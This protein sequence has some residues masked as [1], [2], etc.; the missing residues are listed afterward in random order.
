MKF[1]SNLTIIVTMVSVFAIIGSTSFLGKDKV[2]AQSNIFG[3]NSGGLI[4]NLFKNFGT[5]GAPSSTP[6]VPPST[7]NNPFSSMFGSAP[8]STP[9]NTPVEKSSPTSNDKV[10]YHVGEHYKGFTFD[11]KKA[12]ENK[13]KEACN[14]N[15]ECI[16]CIDHRA[17][18]SNELTGYEAV[19]CLKDPIHSY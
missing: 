7:S 14:G 11:H 13:A 6:S 9:S 15:N 19:K 1:K 3:D 10:K 5:F 16:G 17:Q 18:L 12:S 4:G 8:I 2:F